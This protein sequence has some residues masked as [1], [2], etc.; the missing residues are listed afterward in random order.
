MASAATVGL[1][2]ILPLM[3]KALFRDTLGSSALSIFAIAIFMM[4]MIQSYQA[5]EQSKNHFRPAFYAVVG[6][7]MQK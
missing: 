4:S 1:I 3:N 2:L 7:I 5:I 6:A